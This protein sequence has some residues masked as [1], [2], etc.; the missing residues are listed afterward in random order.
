[1]IDPYNR[2]IDYLRISVTDRCN[3]RCIYCMPPEGIDAKGREEMLRYEEIERVVREF[4]HLG[5]TRFRITGGEP[6]VRKGI[7][8]LIQ[9]LAGLEGVKDLSL[10]TNGLLLDR[11][12]RELKQ[13]GLRRVNVSL[14]S[15]KSE[16]YH[17]ITR[18]G[19]F[20]Q[21]LRGIH[22]ALE[23]GLHPVKLNVVVIREVN[24]DEV[25]DFV[26]LARSLPV[27]V[28]FIEFMPMGEDNFWSPQR[29]V[30]SEEVK[31]Y[32]LRH[33]PLE[34]L[35]PPVSEGPS[36]WEPGLPSPF[37]SE[38]F[39]MV[40]NGPASYYRTPGAA[41]WVG[42][43]G[44]MTRHSCHRCNRLRLTAEG[45][46]RSCLLADEETDLRGALREGGS[47]EELRRLIERAVRAKPPGHSLSSSGHAHARGQM[48][49][50]GG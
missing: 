33:Y 6:L 12:A 26:E 2:T 1:M 5:V 44:S 13:A 14:D 23:V 49:A 40:G 22:H 28:R 19:D 38:I 34:P 48:S 18:G 15:L 11:Y 45:R 37:P 31:A 9:D 35:P 4:V 25:L 20:H 17:H 39:S 8:G 10:T 32:V 29:L 16:R 47:P 27:W 41:G 30:S 7:T 21:V 3:V 24:D 42:F 46:L 36:A 50:I 43:I